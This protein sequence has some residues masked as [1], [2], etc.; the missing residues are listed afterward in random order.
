MLF[1]SLLKPVND[2]SFTSWITRCELKLSPR[3]FSSKKINA[4]YRSNLHSFPSLDP[5]F[6]VETLASTTVSDTL[7]VNPQTM[8]HFFRPLSTWIIPHGNF[9]NACIDCLMSSLKKQRCYVFLKSWR[10]VARP[11]CPIHRCLLNQLPCRHYESLRTFPDKHIST[12]RCT[13]DS[14]QIKK[15]VLLALKI[16]RQICRLENDNGGQKIIAAYR[17]LMEL[18]MSAG[19][20]RGLAC[21]LF[22]K[23]TPERG[24]LRHSGARML[25]LLGAFSSSPF[26]RMC[27]LILTGYVIGFFSQRENHIFEVIAKERCLLYQCNTFEI[28][29]FSNIFPE[30]EFPSI[31]RR[32][33]RL[34]P[35]FSSQRFEDFVKGFK[36]V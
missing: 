35:V 26:E 6:S 5:D 25:M 33:E 2:E 34:R 18:F 31:L 19:E 27:A 4:N 32:L 20:C 14:Q 15:F 28:G 1:Y 10:Y 29:K 17:F 16:Q 7:M 21:F 23:P 9:Q 3:R 36:S 8:L 24:E 30:K 13:L 11:I 12:N 22:S